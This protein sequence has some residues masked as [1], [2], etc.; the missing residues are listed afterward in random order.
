[1][2]PVST[3][4]NL[5][6][7]VF[8]LFRN[9][10]SLSLLDSKGLSWSLMGYLYLYHTAFIHFVRCLSCDRS[11][12]SPDESFPVSAFSLSFLLLSVKVQ[13]NRRR[14]QWPRGLRRESAAIRLLGWRVRIPLG[15][16]ISVFYECCVLSGRGLYVG[17]I[18][19]PE[20]TYRV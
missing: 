3:A 13:L 9:S 16:C 10:G 5:A 18:T 12:S 17:L 7:F 14:F 4:D 1:M 15:P 6:T 2:R 11:V 20:E 8:R 19:R